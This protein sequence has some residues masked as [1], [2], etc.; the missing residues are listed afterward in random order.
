M[1]LKGSKSKSSLFY[2]HQVPQSFHE[3][4]ILTGYRNPQS[5]AFE[6]LYLNNAFNYLIRK[7]SSVFIIKQ[8]FKSVFQANNETVNIWSH[9]L[10]GLFFIYCSFDC[11]LQYSSRKEAWPFLVYLVSYNFILFLFLQTLFI[12]HLSVES[13]EKR[14]IKINNIT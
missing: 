9:F 10:C 1:K 7:I 8:C 13:K 6:V 11:F 14:L 12:F 2:K 5:S 3:I 4:G